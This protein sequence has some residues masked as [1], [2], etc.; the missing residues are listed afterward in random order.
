MTPSHRST[1]TA[2]A[3]ILAGCASAAGPTPSTEARAATEAEW[4]ALRTDP[5]QPLPDAPA[6]S[7]LEARIGGEWTGPGGQHAALAAGLTDLVAAGLMRRADVDFVERRR[8]G[9]AAEAERL[10][11]TAPARQPPPGVTRSLDYMVQVTWLP[12][13]GGDA[14][15]EVQL[16]APGS[17]E[18]VEGTRTTMPRSSDPV[19]VARAIVETTLQLVDQRATRPP[20]QD[21]L[22]A[23]MSGTA[24]ADGTSGVSHGAILE[25]LDGLAAEDRWNW[26]GA[27]RGYQAAA[28]SPSFHEARILLARAARL[29]L[30]GTLAEN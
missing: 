2:L 4:R 20:W 22:A 1:M 14:T 17:G 9:P 5:V 13:P 15:A 29:R 28:T 7:V 24:N 30:G 21:P 26:E 3:L 18:V 16:V 8:F 23:E 6:L 10:G 12:L 19:F 25:F 27:R 11:R